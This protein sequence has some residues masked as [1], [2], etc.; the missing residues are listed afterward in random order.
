[1][2]SD[3]Q[4][5]LLRWQLQARE[6]IHRFSDMKAGDHL[7]RKSISLGISYEHHFLC[8][9]F[10]SEGRP[11]IIHYYNTAA[12]AGVQ[13][14]HTSGQGSGSANERL[15][16]VQVTTLP[17][18]DFIKDEDELQAKGSEVERVVWPEELRRYFVQEVICRA[19]ERE[20][21]KFYD[22]KKNN[23]E[24]FVMWCLCD[25]NISLQ[26]TPLRKALFDTGSG[27]VRSIWHFLQQVFKVGTELL[28]DF[29]TAVG[30]RVIRSAVGQAAPKALSA[31]A[32]GVGAAVTAIVEAVMAGK[33]IR[34]AY[35]KWEVGILIKSREEFIKEATDIVLLALCRSGGSILGMIVG[36]VLMPIPVVG[37]LVGAVLGVLGGHL[38]GKFV[39]EKCTKRLARFIESKIVP[40]LEKVYDLMKS[41]GFPSFQSSSHDGSGVQ[42]TA[43]LRD[44]ISSVTYLYTSNSSN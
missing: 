34:T 19:W 4:M 29:A 37:G 31:A 6:P 24:S 1:M 20:G 35:K 39:S 22:L 38:L 40:I 10:E 18:K 5:R 11:T 36:Q 15:G 32:A 41:E 26:V 25:L 33:D 27:V 44:V 13:M 43:E 2:K 12:N 42:H 28:D 16:I 8:I 9:G 23:C 21:E 7:V 3:E 14:I 30:R 17:H